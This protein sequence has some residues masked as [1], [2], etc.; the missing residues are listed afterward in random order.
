MTGR[1]HKVSA[2][3]LSTAELVGLELRLPSLHL[4]YGKFWA[5]LRLK[6]SIKITKGTCRSY[7]DVFIKLLVSKEEYH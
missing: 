2:R 3:S 7:K 1:E 4:L 6:L 5:F